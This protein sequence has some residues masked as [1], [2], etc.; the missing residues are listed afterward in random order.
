MHMTEGLINLVDDDSSQDVHSPG[1]PASDDRLATT[2]LPG[3]APPPPPPSR[4]PSSHGSQASAQGVVVPPA[5]QSYP[6]GAASPGGALYP[7]EPP[8]AMPR[9]SWWRSLI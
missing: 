1:M 3:H 5:R 6:T 7:S 8:S 9:T 4:R 2:R